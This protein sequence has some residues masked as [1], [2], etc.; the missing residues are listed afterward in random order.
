VSRQTIEPPPAPTVWMSIIGTCMGSPATSRPPVRTAAPPATRHTSV[1]VPPMSNAITFSS[2]L[3]AAIRSVATTPPAGPETRI[4]A[5]CAAA[6]ESEA[7]P[8]EDRITSGSGSPAVAVACRSA[9]R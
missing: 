5:G 3:T 6:S 1:D 9:P 8:P 7:T 4:T 2:P